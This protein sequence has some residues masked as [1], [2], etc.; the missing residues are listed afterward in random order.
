MGELEKELRKISR[1]LNDLAKKEL[2]ALSHRVA[3]RMR[4]DGVTG[5][6]VTLKVKYSDFTLITRSTTLPESTDDASEIYSSACTLLEKTAM[7]KR[8]VR[9]LGISISNLSSEPESQLSLF[10]EGK[11]PLKKTKLNTALD[12]IQEKFGDKGIRPGTLLTK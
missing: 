1:T 10:H 3:H 2:L 6:T 5:E 4:Q 9:L 8:P 7:G 11:S 12:S